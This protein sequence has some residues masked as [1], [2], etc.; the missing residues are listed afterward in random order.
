MWPEMRYRLSFSVGGLLVREAG[1]AAAEFQ[2]LGDWTLVREALD[3]DNLLQARTASSGRRLAREVVQR[4]GELTGPELELLSEGTQSERSHLMWVA[5][6]RRY[7]LVG[8]F[9]EEVLRERF[10]ILARSLDH[11][12]FDQFMRQKEIWHEEL[13]DLADSTY[14]KLRSNLFLMLHESGMFDDAGGIVPVVLSG[15][16]MALF[17]EH[18]P[19]DVRFFPTSEQADHGGLR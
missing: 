19:S 4:L 12:D 10:L 1:V 14:R 5:V 17:N 3:E 11:D 13:A 8:E 6:C 16:T 7:A 15:R 9:A 18:D 2:R